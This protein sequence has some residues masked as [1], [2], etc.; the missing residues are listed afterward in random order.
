MIRRS[1]ERTAEERFQMLGGK[2]T[3]RLYPLFTKGEYLGHAR[4]MSVVELQPG[5]SVG[6]HRH[7]DEEE[8]VYILSG[9]AVYYDNGEKQELKPGDAAITISGQTHRI[10]N[11]GIEPLTY[12]AM[13]LTYGET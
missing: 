10:D 13:V 8:F 5:C 12:L 2:G 6:E 4:L 7:D 11:E 9:T 1:L 3:A